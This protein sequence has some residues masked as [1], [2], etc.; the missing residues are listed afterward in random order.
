MLLLSSNSILLKF[1]MK[2]ENILIDNLRVNYKIA[3]SG[4]AILVL[5]GWGS[6]SESW[7]KI[8]EFLAKRGYFVVCPDLPGFGKS[9]TPPRPWEVGDYVKWLNNFIEEVKKFS[10]QSIEPFFLLGHSFG[11]RIA[12]RLAADYPEK[13]K[14]LILCDTAGIKTKPN[15]KTKIILFTASLGDI[16]F[17]LKPLIRFKDIARNFFYMFLSNRDYIKANTIMRETIKKVLEEDLSPELPKIKTKTLIIWGEKDRI[18]P[19]KYAYIFKEKIRESKLE[20]LPKIGHS[21]YLENPKLL[22][23]KILSFLKEDEF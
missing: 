4:P 10:S 2:E 1:R 5:H 23:E 7:L 14:K 13:L 18:V 20:I 21:P 12:I 19:V 22:S 11:G 9:E 15:I 16:L 6:S 17:S 8:Q 3:G